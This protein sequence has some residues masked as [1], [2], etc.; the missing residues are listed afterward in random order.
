M[1]VNEDESRETAIDPCVW[2]TGT[3]PFKGGFGGGAGSAL[4]LGPHSLLEEEWTRAVHTT[5]CEEDVFAWP[6]SGSILVKLSAF[7]APCIGLLRCVILG[8]EECSTLSFF[9]LCELRAGERLVCEKAVPRMSRRDRLIS[10]SAAPVGLGIDIWK[11]CRVR[12][13]PRG[14]HRFCLAVIKGDSNI[15]VTRGLVHGLTSRPPGTTSPA[16]LDELLFFCLD[17]RCILGRI[18]LGGFSP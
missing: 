6:Y 3:V 7:W 18:C 10:V 1:A 2:L 5:V 15:Q 11:S 9:S 17:I 8:L 13:L 16:M 4:L 14:I 12:D